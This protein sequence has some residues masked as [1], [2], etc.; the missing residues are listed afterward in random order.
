MKLKQLF[1]LLL[2]LV[3]TLTSHASFFGDLFGTTPQPDHQIVHEDAVI[4]EDEEVISADEYMDSIE[5]PTNIEVFSSPNESSQAFDENELYVDDEDEDSFIKAETIFLSYSQKLEKIYLSQHA[6]INV[7]AIITNEKL[8]DIHT[9]FINGK[10][11]EILN[12]DRPWQKISDTSYENSYIVKLFSTSAKLPDIKISASSKEG[13][14]RHKTLEAYK[15]KIVAL[16]EDK[17]FCLVLSEDFTLNNHHEKKYDE[18]SNIVLLEINA[19]KANLEDFHIPYAIRDGID[20]IKNT[21]DV[22]S[23]YYFAIIPNDIKLFK[24]KYF[25]LISNKYHIVS[26]PIVLLDSSV[27]TQTDLNP[28]KSKYAL[29]KAVALIVLGLI[30]FLFYLRYK[31][32]Y[33]LLFSLIVFAYVLYT[34]IPI[35]KLKLQEGMALRIL[36][37]KNST[38]FYKTEAPIEADILLKKDGYIKVLLPNKKIGWID[39]DLTKN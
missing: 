28:Q 31:K 5:E 18:K 37:T 15:P 7:K 26:F 2:L 33:L 6:T 13:K 27:S 4:I 34:Q 23:I 3:F 16:R 20:E 14:V 19:S 8:T 29:Y 32:H 30:I 38:I 25:D 9:S 39:E 11:V 17:A 12:K 36:P 1:T 35:S 21:G 10:N 22:Q 24:F